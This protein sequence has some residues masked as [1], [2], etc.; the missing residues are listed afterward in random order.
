MNPQKKPADFDVSDLPDDPGIE[1]EYDVMPIDSQDAD[2]E[3]PVE[4]TQEDGSQ[5]GYNPRS[6]DLRLGAVYDG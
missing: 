4:T 2:P 3:T 6:L 1:E 5:T